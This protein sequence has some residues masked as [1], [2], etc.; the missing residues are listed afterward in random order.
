[1]SIW[2]ILFWR[3]SASVSNRIYSSKMKW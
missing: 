1:L 2:I 3:I